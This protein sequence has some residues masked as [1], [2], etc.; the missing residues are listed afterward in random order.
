MLTQSM[1]ALVMIVGLSNVFDSHG[2]TNMPAARALTLK[3]RSGTGWATP[4]SVEHDYSVGVMTE[5]DMKLLAEIQMMDANIEEDDDWIVTEVK[6]H[7]ISKVVRRTGSSGHVTDS[8][9]VRILPKCTD[10]DDK[11]VQADAWIQDQPCP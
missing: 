4:V 8:E 1:K 3:A 2:L 6:E 9:H 5:I 7:R 11:W 10:G